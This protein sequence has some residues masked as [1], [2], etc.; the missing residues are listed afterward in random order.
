M[1][2]SSLREG[3][4][5]LILIA[6]GTLAG[7]LAAELFLRGFPSAGVRLESFRIGEDE[8]PY[9]RVMGRPT[10]RGFYRPSDLLGYEHEPG[11]P[12]RTNRYGLMGRAHPLEKRPGVFRVLL[13]GDSIAEPFWSGETL[14]DALD[15]L[16]REPGS[17]RRFE[18]WNA[19]TGS[20]D[21]RRYS[22]FLRHRGLRFQ[23]DL[24][25]VFLS[26]NDFGIDTNTYYRDKDG[27]IG[28][29]FPLAALRR[30]GVVPSSWLLRRSALYRFALMRA[31]AWLAARGGGPEATMKETGLRYVREILETGRAHFLPVVFVVFPYLE[32]PGRLDE[33]QRLEY[34]TITG[35]LSK[36]G[37]AWLD[38]SGLF[39]GMRRSG[40][41]LRYK[42]HDIVHP[43]AKAHEAISRE[44]GSFLMR[45]RLL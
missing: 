1:K 25:V 20:Y 6:G 38:L 2:P 21:I 18:V 40:A 4:A 9:M 31:E 33:R 7:L 35:V 5:A 17:R 3:A 15:S 27:F 23:P 10:R 44:I 36:T 16:P 41:P 8:A 34:S 45:E 24:A 32:P 11:V 29:H 28:Y 42:P 12:G 43:S 39:E 14:E 26:M 22:L 19:G 30:R 37:A 13:L